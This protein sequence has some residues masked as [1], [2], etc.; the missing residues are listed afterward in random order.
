MSFRCLIAGSLFAGRSTACDGDL[1][2]WDE[3]E[4]DPPAFDAVVS[5]V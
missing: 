2:G 3:A 1:T 5:H 4:I